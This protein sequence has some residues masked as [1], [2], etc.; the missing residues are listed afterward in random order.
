[1]SLIFLLSLA[2]TN[3][4]VDDTQTT[5]DTSVADDTGSDDT[6]GN[7]TGGE[8]DTYDFTS[9]LTNEDS[10]SYGGQTF[11]NLMISDMKSYLGGL[12]ERLNSGTYFP[13]EGEVAQDLLFYLEFDAS[14]GGAVP[15]ALST[16][17]AVLQ[18]T[19]GDMS[20][21]KSVF[22]KLAGNDATGQHKDWNNGAMV[23]W[24]ADS[25]EALVRAWIDTVDAQAVAWS[26][27]NPPLGPDGSPV[28]A[29][30]VT[31]EGQDLQQL[32]EKFL[33][34]GVGYSQGADDYMDDDVD[35][36]GLL[37]GHAEADEGKAYTALEHAW[38]EGFGYFG[39]SRAYGT[40][41]DDEIK[42]KYADSDGDGKINLETEYCFGH[43]VNAAKRDAGAVAATDYTAQAWEGFMQGRAL[44][45]ETAGSDLSAEDFAALQGHRDAAL[46]AW[47]RAISATAVHY[48]NDTLQDMNATEYSFADHAKHWSEL[49]GFALIL[50]FNPHSP[51]TDAQFADLHSL[52]GE[53]PVLPTDAGAAEYKTD[54]LEARDLLQ[55]AYG[56]D[57]QNMGDDNGEGGW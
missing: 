39:A 41:T 9:S 38:D 35:G 57:A 15:I 13:E 51:M 10:V 29:V 26:L 19:Y 18:A 8:S 31:P 16:D 40:W 14:T 5:D 4:D 11:R 34:G 7:D 23:G 48:I 42:A 6:G 52:L 25:P 17:P 53:A 46:D 24:D 28:P 36:K 12:T 44:L 37:A 56:F 20:S 49:K 30:Y 54:L 47:E 43:S 27:G 3:S 45:A 2:C 33:Q 50:Q 32:L 21:Q 22:G 1:M 55:A